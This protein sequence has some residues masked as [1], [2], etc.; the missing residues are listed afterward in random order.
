[1]DNESGRALSH[2]KK[3]EEKRE[4]SFKTLLE[5]LFFLRVFLKWIDRSRHFEEFVCRLGVPFSSPRIAKR[6]VRAGERGRTTTASERAP[7]SSALSPVRTAA[8]H[9]L[10]S[11]QGRAPSPPKACRCAH[12]HKNDAGAFCVRAK[13]GYRG[14]ADPSKMTR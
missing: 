7:C 1:M 8:S 9:R 4:H 14:T 13:V 6:K 12:G 2:K 10:C 5:I 3:E 11:P